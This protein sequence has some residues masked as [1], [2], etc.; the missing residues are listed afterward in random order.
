MQLFRSLTALICHVIDVIGKMKA[1]KAEIFYKAE[2]KLKNIKSL[3]SRGKWEALL[4]FC[5][6]IFF[7]RGNR[8]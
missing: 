5:R 6:Q 7:I 3:A 1:W 8:D 2:F 4:Y